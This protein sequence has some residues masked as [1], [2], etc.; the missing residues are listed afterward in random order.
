MLDDLITYEF[1]GIFKFLSKII[2]VGDVFSKPRI[3][4]VSFGL[5]L[6]TVL[7]LVKIQS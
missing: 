2:L 6:I 5:S 1:I 3:L 7:T 4:H